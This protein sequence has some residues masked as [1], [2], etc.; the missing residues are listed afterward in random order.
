MGNNKD[1]SHLLDRIRRLDVSTI[2]SMSPDVMANLT[3]GFK[4]LL[5]KELLYTETVNHEQRK[6]IR[7]VKTAYKNWKKD[8]DQFWGNPPLYPERYP[9]Y[10][11]DLQMDIECGW[12]V[13]AKGS[14]EEAHARLKVSS[15]LPEAVPI[16]PFPK[17]DQSNKQTNKDA[18]DKDKII[19]ELRERISK[20]EAESEQH[21]RFEQEHSIT[22]EQFDAIFEGGRSSKQEKQEVQSANSQS[23]LP[24]EK[25]TTEDDSPLRTDI[26]ELEKELEKYKTLYEA[27]AKRLDRYE[28]ILGT[29]EELSKGKKFNIAERII[30]CSALL[31]CS[32]SEDDIIQQQMAKMIMR[33][34]GDRWQ[35]IRTTISDMNGKRIAL[36]EV[37]KKAKQEKDVGA[38]LAVWRKE[39][40]N[41]KGLTN[42]ALNVYKY[43]HSAVK[44]GTV[45]AKVHQC[46]QAMENIDH[47]YYLS[48]RKLIKSTDMQPQG[49]KFASPIDEI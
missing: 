31:G 36:D 35:S 34:S 46:R 24:V 38:R 27:A 8:T 41:F 16:K 9:E 6:I 2:E 20:L 43:L 28:T 3:D 14:F 47:A 25:S 5:I 7:A 17:A 21:N 18:D 13:T 1:Y 42:A 48:E 45:G 40:D 44:G 4:E 30:F 19:A 37:A 29:E 12:V 33:F 11:E 23:F 49:D 26:E 22:K 32:L 15:I 10:M 39:E